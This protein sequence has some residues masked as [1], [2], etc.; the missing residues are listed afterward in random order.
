MNPHVHW[1]SSTCRLGW[2]R[3]ELAG[4]GPS[5]GHKRD[6]AVPL[7]GLASARYNPRETE[8]QPMSTKGR[9]PE[10]KILQS[11]VEWRF[12]KAHRYWDDCGKLVSRIEEAFPG[13]VCQK[14]AETGFVFEGSSAGI[15]SCFFYWDKAGLTRA[16]EGNAMLPAAVETYWPLVRDGLGI[17]RLTRVGHRSW[18]CFPTASPDEATRRLE[19]VPVWQQTAAASSFGVPQAGGSVLR[20]KIEPN[21]RRLRLAVD[22]G[23][24]TLHGQLNHGIIVD[25]D[26]GVEEPNDMPESASELVARNISFLRESV[27][28]AF[29]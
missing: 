7:L 2:R 16:G 14:L 3:P 26:I 20:T 10:P 23:T 15:T 27:A 1:R 25:A 17:E 4:S 9:L 29:R 22:A 8:A 12:A 6:T 11:A 24:L 19:S 13:L 18:L 21:G 28:P 5:Q